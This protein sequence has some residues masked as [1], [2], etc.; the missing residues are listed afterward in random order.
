M[1]VLAA[2]RALDAAPEVVLMTAYAEVPA[3]VEALRAGAYDYLAKP[4]EPQDVVRIATRAADRF[5]LVRRTREL[6]ALVEAGESG[7]IGRSAAAIEVRR[8]IERA[9]R[10]PAPVVL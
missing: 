3:A 7:F 8:R 9:G 6:E 1:E 5:A 10:L 2:A 4:V